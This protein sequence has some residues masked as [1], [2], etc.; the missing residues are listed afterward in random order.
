MACTAVATGLVLYIAIEGVKRAI[1]F[2]T[3]VVWIE[4]A[5]IVAFVI[6]L[7][8]AEFTGHPGT[9]HPHWSWLLPSTSPSY[10]VS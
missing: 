1:R 6:A 5:I 4:Y 2:Q 7:Y 8:V 9:T 10:S 3:I